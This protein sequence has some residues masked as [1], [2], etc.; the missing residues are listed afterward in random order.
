[1]KWKQHSPTFKQKKVFQDRSSGSDFIHVRKW[2]NFFG[3][4]LDSL[5][6]SLFWYGM[7]TWNTQ[8]TFQAVSPQEFIDRQTKSTKLVFKMRRKNEN[9]AYDPPDQCTFL[10]LVLLSTRSEIV[11]QIQ[12]GQVSWAFK[13]LMARLVERNLEIWQVSLQLP[14]RGRYDGRGWPNRISFKKKFSHIT[15][16]GDYNYM[17]F[18]IFFFYHLRSETLIWS[19]SATSSETSRSLAMIG[20]VSDKEKELAKFCY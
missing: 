3:A 6:S 7:S 16:G 17:W 9:D 13:L 18:F 4:T 12:R 20:F 10:F 5:F 1:M 15:R 2:S 14:S 11:H 19:I 8:Q